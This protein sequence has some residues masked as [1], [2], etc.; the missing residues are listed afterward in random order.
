MIN[1]PRDFLTATTPTASSSTNRAVKFQVLGEE[2][3]PPILA[4][5]RRRTPSRRKPA[6][7]KQ[8][9]ERRVSHDRRRTTF[10]SKA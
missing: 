1:M 6:Q 9:I 10:S 3:H 2:E 4:I 8:Q 7:D 5:E